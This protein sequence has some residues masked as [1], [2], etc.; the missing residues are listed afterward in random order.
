MTRG[1]GAHTQHRQV[2][3]EPPTCISHARV[4]VTTNLLTVANDET[5]VNLNSHSFLSTSG[6]LFRNNGRTDSLRLLR[7]VLQLFEGER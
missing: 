3:K 7:R 1:D 6:D 2:S 5:D 4:S